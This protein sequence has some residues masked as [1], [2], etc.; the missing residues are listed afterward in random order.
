[1]LHPSDNL[2]RYNGTQLEVYFSTVQK[3]AG[4]LAPRREEKQEKSHLL[5]RQPVSPFPS[6]NLSPPPSPVRALSLSVSTEYRRLVTT[7]P[8][9]SGAPSANNGI[10][11]CKILARDHQEK[12][13]KQREDNK[14]SA[15]NKKKKRRD[16]RGRSKPSLRYQIKESKRRE[17]RKEASRP[18]DISEEGKG[19]GGMHAPRILFIRPHSKRSLQGMPVLARPSA[20][21]SRWQFNKLLAARVPPT[22]LYSGA[23]GKKGF[24]SR[25]VQQSGEQISV[26]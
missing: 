18:K 9:R 17:K 11:E 12:K 3:P 13:N 1:M 2:L 4:H 14:V 7:S 10:S 24:R 25:T 20:P 21:A 22:G 26:R 6:L 23:R 16:A 5:L 8:A 15:R 19:R